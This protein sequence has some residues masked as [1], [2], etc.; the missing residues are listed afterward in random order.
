MSMAEQKLFEKGA[1]SMSESVRAQIALRLLEETRE[2]LG[3][4]DS[5][6]NILI[7]AIVAGAGVA[8]GGLASHG[9]SLLAHDWLVEL[10]FFVGLSFVAASVV[11][12]VLAVKPHLR[13]SKSSDVDYFGDVVSCGSPEVLADRL[14]LSEHEVAARHIRQLWTLSGVVIRRYRAIS[15][16][17]SL[18]GMGVALDC[19][20]LAIRTFTS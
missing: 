11:R 1:R 17:M 18:L 7:A 14:D 9:N 20:A 4:A 13:I 3:R 15:Q 12:L 16:A 19:V 10:F 8:F 2:E 5:K 6:A